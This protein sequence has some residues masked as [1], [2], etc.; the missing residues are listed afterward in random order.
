MSSNLQEGKSVSIPRAIYLLAI[1]DGSELIEL[2]NFC[3][4]RRDCMRAQGLHNGSTTIKTTA[5]LVEVP[6]LPEQ[7]EAIEHANERASERALGRACGSA[8]N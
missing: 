1:T 3:F 5:E 2:R 4:N 7:I 6:L 8:T